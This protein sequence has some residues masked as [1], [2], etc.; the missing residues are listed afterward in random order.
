ARPRLPSILSACST[1]SEALRAIVTLPTIVA[2]PPADRSVAGR[3]S[4]T[5]VLKT[6]PAF[7]QPVAPRGSA[8]SRRCTVRNGA[9]AVPAF[10]LLPCDEAQRV[11]AADAA[12]AAASITAPQANTRA[13]RLATA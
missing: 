12:G 8:A 7:R 1:T 2:R 4:Q 13:T 5:R 9:L 10:R 3:T 11:H 6:E